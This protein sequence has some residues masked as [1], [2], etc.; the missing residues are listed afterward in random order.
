M[1]VLLIAVCLFLALSS[2]GATEDAE[3]SFTF[4]LEQSTAQ[5]A[6]PPW[7]TGQPT[8]L[9]S[10]HATVGFPITPPSDQ[11]DLAVTFYFTESMGGFLRVFW[12]GARTSE[13]LSDNL[14][15]GIAM[16]NQ[17]TVLIKRSTLSS[18]GTLTLQSSETTL[19]VSRIHFEWVDPST[20]SL[21]DSAKQSS[22]I[23]ATGKV[24]K[25]SDVNGAPPLPLA[26][27]IGNSVVT[28]SLDD[29][30]V[31]IEAGVEFVAAL[32]SMPQFARLEIR[33]SGAPVGKPVVLTL[34]GSPAGDI[35]MEVPDLNDP[36][37]QADAGL[38]SKYVGWRK[39]VI[40]VSA[41]QLKVGDNQFQVG[42]KDV[43]PSG[44]AS[45][46]AVKELLLQLKYPEQAPVV[47]QVAPEQPAEAPSNPVT[48]G[49]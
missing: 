33:L 19:D 6:L 26:D 1:N 16:P 34:N 42:L 49:T 14:F 30:P 2:I 25:D 4:N 38:P 21:S 28:A 10:A 44:T 29:K 20:V 11:S 31:R 15:E 40:Y 43:V 47:Q 37:Y 18:S 7:M 23:D 46:L 32:Q 8:A 22:L 3:R 17:R 5:Q 24:F 39:G 9:P 45:P 36:G 27:Q 35:S 48:S 12:A 41:S 13:M